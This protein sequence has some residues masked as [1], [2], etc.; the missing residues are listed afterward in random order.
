MIFIRH[1]LF[2]HM[3]IEILEEL[4]FSSIQGYTV[5]PFVIFPQKAD[6]LAFSVGG[7]WQRPTVWTIN[8]YRDH[9]IF[10]WGF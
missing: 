5:I 2:Q 10:Y 8:I 4:N 9:F 1:A 7:T 6:F 3:K